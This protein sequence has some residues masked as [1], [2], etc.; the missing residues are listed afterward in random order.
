MSLDTSTARSALRLHYPVLP[1]APTASDLHRLFT[2]RPKE[3]TWATTI[4]RT[5][6]S[7][8][9]LLVQL[10]TFQA[11]GRFLP[12]AQIPL[13]AIEHI[14]MR[15][16]VREQRSSQRAPVQHSIA[17]RPRSSI[18]SVSPRGVGRRGHWP[19]PR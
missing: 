12:V 19:S 2:P 11:V 17:T 1:A 10:C 7:Q 16:G 4:A 15:L 13:S 14:S 5:T 9:S 6:V 3:R 18:I 8:V